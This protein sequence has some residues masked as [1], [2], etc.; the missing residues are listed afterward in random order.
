MSDEEVRM[1]DVHADD[2][3]I[4]QVLD[5]NAVAGTLETLFGADMT[6]VPQR[7]A[8]CGTVSMV[9]QLR[10]YLRGPGSVLRCPTC[11]GIVLRIVET[12]EATYIDARGAAYLRI[13]RERSAR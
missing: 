7:C 13:E 4:D 5:G 1:S 10:A 9:G 8:H 11:E 3:A 2:L 6:A 12:A